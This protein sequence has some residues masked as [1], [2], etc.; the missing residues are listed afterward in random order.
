M[1]T[2]FIP[3][4][5]ATTCLCLQLVLPLGL[6]PKLDIIAD[7]SQPKMSMLTAG[8]GLEVE[9]HGVVVRNPNE[10]D[11]CVDHSSYYEESKIKAPLWADIRFVHGE[12]RQRCDNYLLNMALDTSSNKK[13]KKDT[14]RNKC[15]R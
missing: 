11:F 13:L 15:K 10:K 9:L 3:M 2:V 5:L 1:L 14:Y 8:I 6:R 12:R 7:K 4:S